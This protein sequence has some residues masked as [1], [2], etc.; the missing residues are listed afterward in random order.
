[1]RKTLADTVRSS[2]GTPTGVALSS[3]APRPDLDPHDG[4]AH[5]VQFYEQDP[6]LVEGVSRFI[7]TALGAGDAAIVIATG[8]HREMLAE[9]LGARGLDVSAVAE[10]GRYVALDAGATLAKILVDGWPDETRFVD[11]VGGVIERAAAAERPPQV[12]AFGEMVALLCAEGR[13]DA[14]IR[15]EQLWNNLAKRIPFSLFCAYP[16]GAFRREADGASFLSI[17]SAHAHVIPAESYTGLTNPDERLRTISQLQQKAG[18][19]ENAVTQQNRLQAELEGKLVQLAEVDRQK[20]EFLAMLGHELRNPLSAVR[21]ALAAASLDPSRR[22]RVLEIA[23][24]QTDQL[25]RLVD[26]LLDVARITEGKIRLRTQR[27]RLA[28][29]VER[30]VESTRQLIEERMHAI[31]LSLAGDV[32]V[33]ADPTRLEQVVVNLISN[34]ANYTE[35]G[36]RIDIT[37][38]RAGDHVLL[39]VRDSGAGIAPEMLPH[40]FD[41]FAQG[42]RTLDRSQGGLGI[43]LTVVRRLVELH[44]GQVEAHSDGPGKGAEFVVKLPACP[45]TREE[46]AEVAG[47]ESVQPGCARV[48]VVEDN[49][50]AAESLLMLLEVLGHRVRMA[51]DGVTAIDLARASVPDVMLVDIGLPGVDGYEIARRVRRDPDLRHVILVALTGYGGEE[52]KRKA[53]AAGFNHHLVK[54]VNVDALEQLVARFGEAELGRSRSTLH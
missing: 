18:A 22:E 44:D 25:G 45:P 40:I 21:N 53:L 11:V 48:L 4:P 23:R 35:P 42:D 2:D 20:D 32:D 24:R 49:H 6:F 30:A 54:P 47:A 41:L 7:G 52:D 5:F 16:I 14:A 10:Q 34:A 19:L 36:G 50:D 8:S 38:R 15:L 28:S 26:D 13:C 43:G 9:A 37:E 29:V 12:R 31:S 17:C 3:M 46:A 1:M 51:H 33:E 27:V 39:R